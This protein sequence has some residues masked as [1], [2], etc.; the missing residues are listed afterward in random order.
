MGDLAVLEVAADLF[1]REPAE[2]VHGLGRPLDGAVHRVLDAAL[3][4]AGQLDGLVHVLGHG[5]SR[6]R[7][8]VLG[9]CSGGRPRGR[10]GRLSSRGVPDAPICEARARPCP[11]GRTCAPA[12]PSLL[13]GTPCR[14]R[15]LGT[16][17]TAKLTPLNPACLCDCFA[18]TGGGGVS[19]G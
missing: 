1:H 6:V 2:V 13:P 12:G 9:S 11:L 3:R 8:I 7:N 5:D 16:A 14:H 15:D 10:P 18:L 4:G 17:A 19:G